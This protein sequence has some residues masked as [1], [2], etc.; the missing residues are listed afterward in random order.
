MMR[1]FGMFGP[2]GWIGMILNLVLFLAVVIG[3]IWL[4]VSVVRRGSHPASAVPP[5][6]PAAAGPTPREIVQ[7]R[8]AKGEINRE[9]YLQL[10]TDLEK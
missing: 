4:V 9:E 5:L 7:A 8:Y 1:G 2:L 10:M 6:P 3:I